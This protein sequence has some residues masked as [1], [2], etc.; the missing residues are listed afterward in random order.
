MGAAEFRELAPK[1]RDREPSP[2]IR[3]Q[4][5]QRFELSLSRRQ[6]SEMCRVLRL[7]TI[8]I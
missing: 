5:T 6:H 2:S 1:S 8:R 3:N 7:R 4:R